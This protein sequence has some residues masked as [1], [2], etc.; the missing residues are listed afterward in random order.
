MKS[1]SPMMID[2][3]TV[4]GCATYGGMERLRHERLALA[5]LSA[6]EF[7]IFVDRKRRFFHDPTTAHKHSARQTR[8]QKMYPIFY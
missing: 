1:Y 2:K 8:E 3:P 4:V 7:V 6:F 5:N